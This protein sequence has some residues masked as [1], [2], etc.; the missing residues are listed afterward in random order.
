MKLLCGLKNV[1]KNVSLPICVDLDGTLV[2][3]DT[4]WVLIRQLR[5]RQFF[6]FAKLVGLF[7]FKGR[8][9]FKK[10]LAQEVTLNP[11]HLSYNKK[12]LQDL[13]RMFQQ[14]TPLVLVTGADLKVAQ[15]IA[16]YLGIFQIVLGS[17]G[18]QNLVSYA[19][20]AVLVNT[21][22]K[23]KFIYAGNAWQDLPVWEH[24]AH[25][26]AVNAPKRLLKTLK[27]KATPQKQL[28]IYE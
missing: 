4:L 11:V 24:A 26:V 17:N 18:S 5:K 12:F 13:T 23:G 2:R 27:K 3:E 25:M 20:S 15:K 21:F 16:D 10:A 9:A 7:L 14:G 1:I 8:A 6:I 28:K 19:K 22:G